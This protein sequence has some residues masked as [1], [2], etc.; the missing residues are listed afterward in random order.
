MRPKVRVRGEE[1]RK[2]VAVRSVKLDHLKPGVGGIY[3]GDAESLD[4]RVELALGQRAGPGG[5][6]GGPERR[7]G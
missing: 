3:G 4:D 1:L 7:P 6:P 5:L 2:Q